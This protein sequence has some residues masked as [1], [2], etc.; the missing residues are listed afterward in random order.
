MRVRMG[1]RLQLQLQVYLQVQ[2][3]RLRSLLKQRYN[4]SSLNNSSN[5]NNIL[6]QQQDLHLHHQCQLYQLLHLLLL[7]HLKIPPGSTEPSSES[8]SP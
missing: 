4:H 3:V 5:Y 1:M 6:P 7:Q 8:S 2:I